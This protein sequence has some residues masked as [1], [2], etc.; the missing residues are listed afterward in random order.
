MLHKFLFKFFD[1][2]LLFNELLVVFPEDSFRVDDF[3]VDQAGLVLDFEHLLFEIVNFIFELF[4]LAQV[5]EFEVAFFL[6]CFEGELLLLKLFDFFFEFFELIFLFHEVS[7][8]VNI[9]ELSF[10]SEDFVFEFEDFEF[11]FLDFFLFLLKGGFV[12]VEGLLL[13]LLRLF[14]SLFLFGNE[15][16][17]FI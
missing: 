4:L 8:V 3:L 11:L 16:V 2:F 1:F 15:L 10:E 12:L 7:G 17:E 13:I 6:D 5:L 14:C 9:F